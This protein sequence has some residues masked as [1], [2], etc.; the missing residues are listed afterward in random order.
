MLGHASAG[1]ATGSMDMDHLQDQANKED[2]QRTIRGHVS[3]ASITSMPLQSPIAGQQ[4]VFGDPAEQ[5]RQVQ[6]QHQQ[7]FQQSQQPFASQY[8]TRQISIAITG[9]APP[10]R[11]GSQTTTP[12]SPGF[13]GG[14]ASRQAQGDLSA[15]TAGS[16]FFH[17]NSQSALTGANVDGQASYGQLYGGHMGGQYP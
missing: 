14:D 2:H 5:Q 16:A 12:I 4:S 10:S 7:I 1:M 3:K 15:P 8:N 11:D 9:S 13:G 6:Q 17:P